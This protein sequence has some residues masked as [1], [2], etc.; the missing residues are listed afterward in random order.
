MSVQPATAT[1]TA[2]AT[3]AGKK[4]VEA[5]EEEELPLIRILP[6]RTKVRNS[7]AYDRMSYL[8]QASQLMARISIANDNDPVTSTL[9]RYYQQQ[10]H[11][12]STRSVLRITPKVKRSSCRKCRSL[13]VP[14]LSCTQRLVTAHNQRSVLTTCNRCQETRRVPAPKPNLRRRAARKRRQ[15]NR[16]NKS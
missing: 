15:A 16:K 3:P 1:A 7:I 11:Y 6:A 4:P 12:V 13:L 10:M 14:S 8:M 9:S 5:P 2:T